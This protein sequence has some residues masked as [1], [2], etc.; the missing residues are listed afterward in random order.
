VIP[1][2]AEGPIEN[3]QNL[4]P[5]AER[6]RSDWDVR[7][8][9]RN[10]I[11]LVLSQGGVVIFGFA[12]IWL[13]TRKFGS[14]GYGGIVA[15][16]AASQIAQVCVNW[17]SFSL[18]RFGV[19]EFVETQKIAKIFWTRFSIL[20]VNIVLAFL[21]AKI[22]YPYI[23]ASFNFLP[24]TYWLVFGHFAV[25]ALWN[26]VQISLQGAK[27]PSVQGFLL[28]AERISILLGILFF[29]AIGKLY[30]L[31]V[32][33]CYIG[34]SI[35]VTLVGLYW[36]RGYIFSRFPIDPVFY[37]KVILF[38]LPLLPFTLV[39]YFSG[40]QVDY[41]F[42]SRFLSTRDLGVYSVAAQ[43]SGILLQVPTVANSLLIP[44]FV[45]LEKEKQ[46]HKIER[47]FKDVLP[48]LSLGW[49]V[50]CCLGGFVGYFAIPAMFGDQFAGAASPWIVLT[51]AVAV[52]FPVLVGY[53]ALSHAISATYIA[54]FASIFAA[55]INILFNFLLI[56]QYG[57]IGCAWS[58][59]L[60]HSVSVI[61]FA[62]LLRRS[63]NISLSWTAF[64]ILPA[65]AGAIVFTI[66]LNPFWS[67]LACAVVILI[68]SYW[69]RSSITQ[70]FQFL[71]NSLDR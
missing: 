24:E 36:L 50:L 59:V 69:E 52:S 67:L 48:S 66:T 47:F 41:V 6:Q 22:W 16:I 23:A 68:V 70:A 11:L 51:A 34:S 35:A 17:T 46:T 53:S 64:S 29:L 55:C 37:K 15:I 39:G 44:L 40:N 20:V 26:H 62:F 9:P 7:N 4:S 43:M 65:L 13:L 60:A 14:Q 33:L 8:A 3:P 12:A 42:V 57:L 49:C 30:I 61:C 56:S 58:T 2:S 28:M 19:D 27:M 32:I 38:S 1:D 31:S 18:V 45:T 25:L 71:R 5:V 21:L 63:G 10:Y 54:M